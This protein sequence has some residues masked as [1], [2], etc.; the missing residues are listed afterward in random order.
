MHSRGVV[1]YGS[2]NPVGQTGPEKT[3]GCCEVSASCFQQPLSTLPL[4]TFLY[5][6]DRLQNV[7][8]GGERWEGGCFFSQFFGWENFFFFGYPDLSLATQTRFSILTILN[9]DKQR[10]EKPCL[11]AVANEFVALL[12]DHTFRE[13]DLNM[14][15]WHSTAVC[16]GFSFKVYSFKFWSDVGAKL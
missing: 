9:T 1:R 4:R 15:G 8:S 14:S 3:Y 10:T 2:L 13:S 12:R 7:L 6:H 16:V 5:G 11:V